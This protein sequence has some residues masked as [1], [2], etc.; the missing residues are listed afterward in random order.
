MNSLKKIM[1]KETISPDVLRA[2]CKLFQTF[3]LNDDIRAEIPMAHKHACQ[4][5]NEFLNP[6]LF[7]LQSKKFGENF[8]QV[9]YGILSLH[10]F[11]SSEFRDDKKVIVSV[12]QALITIIVRHEYCQNFIDAGG[13]ELLRDIMVENLDDEV[14][15][16]FNPDH[17]R[18]ELGSNFSS[19]SL[20]SM[21]YIFSRLFAEVV[22]V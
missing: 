12:L 4:I 17:W 14:C 11:F 21:L 8:Q 22:T 15:L 7:R 19:I 6:L 18:T 2:I 16:I 20:Y 13:L 5:S 1:E 10:Y 3:V 9:Y